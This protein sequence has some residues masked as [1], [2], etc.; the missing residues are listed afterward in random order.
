MQRAQH[1]D[2]GN[3]RASKLGRNVLGDAGKAQN[4][5]VKHLTGPARRFEIISTVVS[6]TEL[7][8]FSGRGLFDYVCVAFELVTDRCSNEIGAVRIETV[9]H[10]QIHVPKVDITKIGS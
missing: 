6:Q 3:G 4:I 2:G 9:L 1:G 10:H 5:D 8:A 7:Q